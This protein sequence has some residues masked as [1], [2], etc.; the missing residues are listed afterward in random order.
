MV[1]KCR[2]CGWH[3]FYPD[4]PN[5]NQMVTLYKTLFPRSC[6]CGNVYVDDD[7][8]KIVYDDSS[9]VMIWNTI[10]QDWVNAG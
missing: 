1:T 9:S 4:D 2:S 3:I 10:E 5:A 6:R 7:E 8:K